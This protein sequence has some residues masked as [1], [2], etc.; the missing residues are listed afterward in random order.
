MPRLAESF[1]ISDDGLTYTFTLRE[2]VKFHNGDTFSGQDVIDTW[3]MIMNPDFGAFNQNGWDKIADITVDGNQ[4]WSSTTSEVF[5]PFLSY[6]GDGTASRRRAPI[7][8]RRRDNSSRSSAARLIGTGPL[9]FVEWTAEGADRRREIRRLLG[10]AGAPRPDHLSASCRTTTPSSSSSAPAKSRW[11]L[12]ARLARAP[13]RVDEALGID[14][15]ISP[16][17]SVTESGPTSTSSSRIFLRI[18]EG[19]PGARLRHAVPGHHR[20]AA[21]GARDSL[22]SPTRQPGHLGVQPEHPA[23]AVRHRSRPRRCWPRPG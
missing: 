18:T 3:K 13:L 10:R 19:A 11:P 16:R 21:Q 2:G 8:A 1:E 22:E 20:Q 6:V 4:R 9:K 14:G 12:A 7:D 17:A 23:A 5:A 15:V